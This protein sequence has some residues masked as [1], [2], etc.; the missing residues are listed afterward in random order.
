MSKSLPEPLMLDGKPHYSARQI[1]GMGLSGMPGTESGVIRVA[2]RRRWPLLYRPSGRG[3]GKVYP[4]EA[5]P[6]EAQA[7]IRRPAQPKPTQPAPADSAS[8]QKKT[9]RQKAPLSRPRA[10]SERDGR[11]EVGGGRP[12]ETIQEGA[13]PG[14]YPSPTPARLS[15]HSGRPATPERRSGCAKP[16]RSFT[17]TTPYTDGTRLWRRAV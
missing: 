3:G 14:R 5:L 15:A 2:K 12:V 10:G 7:K 17:V 1:A 6:D 8:T 16:F 11:G 13:S 4:L 9:N